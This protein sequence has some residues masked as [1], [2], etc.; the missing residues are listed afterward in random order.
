[1]KVEFSAFPK[2]LTGNVAALVGADK[3]TYLIGDLD[4]AHA[5]RPFNLRMLYFYG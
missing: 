4:P 3:W 5:A 1:M 2:A